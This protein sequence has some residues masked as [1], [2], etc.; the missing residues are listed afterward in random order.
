MLYWVTLCLSPVW[1]GELSFLYCL[2]S[3]SQWVESVAHAWVN[4]GDKCLMLP[5]V[6]MRRWV[7]SS[8]RLLCLFSSETEMELDYLCTYKCLVLFCSHPR[9]TETTESDVFIHFNHFWHKARVFKENRAAEEKRL[10]IV[11]FLSLYSRIFS[12]HSF[13]ICWEC[14]FAIFNASMQLAV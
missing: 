12:F 13:P 5:F 11:C 10:L 6:N 1:T 7:V 8:F 9:T 2:A 4:T 3:I 14:S